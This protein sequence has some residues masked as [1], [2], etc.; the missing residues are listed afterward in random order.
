MRFCTPGSYTAAVDERTRRKAGRDDAPMAAAAEALEGRRLLS[1][2]LL[3]W[4]GVQELAF[5]GTGDILYGSA[6]GQVFRYDAAT[7]QAMVPLNAPGTLL[8]IDV[9]PDGR[10]VYAADGSSPR[11]RKIDA[12]T[13]AVTDLT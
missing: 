2:T 7:G 12:A 9:S 4:S 11:V 1:S 5:D 6:N 8:G 3:P 13:G 10:F